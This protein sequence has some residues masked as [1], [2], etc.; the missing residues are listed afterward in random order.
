MLKAGVG[1]LMGWGLGKGLANGIEGSCI[2][3]E[4]PYS[5]PLPPTHQ[6]MKLKRNQWRKRRKRKLG[7]FLQDR[8]ATFTFVFPVEKW[9][10]SPD[11]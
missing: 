3:K 5:A 1:G 4:T 2:R 8:E 11:P 10:K 9:D 7:S 6:K